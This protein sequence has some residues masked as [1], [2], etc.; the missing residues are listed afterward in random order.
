M[1]LKKVLAHLKRRYGSTFSVPFAYALWAFGER[2]SK[3]EIDPSIPWSQYK[4]MLRRR[5]RPGVKD[6]VHHGDGRSR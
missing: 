1:I 6:S 4:T 5:G 2:F 3:S